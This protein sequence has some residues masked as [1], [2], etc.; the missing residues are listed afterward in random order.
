M[1]AGRLRHAVQLQTLLGSANSF[2]E[3]EPSWQDFDTAWAAIEPLKGREYDAARA[4]NA[5]TT[6]IITLRYR[7]GIVP[8]MRVRWTVAGITRLFAIEEILNR[9]EANKTVQLR[10]TELR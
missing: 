10:A 1:R 8:T 6:H 3:S 7:E 4:R 9:D 2:G 5:E